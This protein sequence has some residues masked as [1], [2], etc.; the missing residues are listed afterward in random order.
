M[1][2]FVSARL[3][4]LIAAMALLTAILP[5]QASVQEPSYGAPR[6]APVDVFHPDVPQPA[7][8]G[9]VTLHLKDL[10]THLNF[11]LVTSTYVHRILYEAHEWLAPYGLE[12]QRPEPVLCR[13]W[14][15]E[16]MLVLREGVLGEWQGRST[17][18]AVRDRSQGS[19]G[20]RAEVDVLFG[21]VTEI[22][23]YYVLRPLSPEN[24]LGT[25]ALVPKDH[26]RSV[27]RGT[28]YTFYLREDVL[29]HPS[30]IFPERE[31]LSPEK[32]A[33]LEGE[34]LDAWDVHFSWSLYSNPEVDCGVKRFQFEKMPRCEVLDDLTVRVFY[35]AQYF[36]A[37]EAIGSTLTVL[38]RH[39]YDLSDPENPDYDPEAT[40]TQQARHVNE[41]PHN[42]LWVGLGPYQI[43]EYGQQHIEARRFPAYFNP[44][45]AGYVD[46]IR[47]RYIPD[48]G[49]A[50][51]ALLNGEID[52]LDRMSGETYL[53]SSTQ[54]EAFTDHYYKGHYYLGAYLYVCWNLHRPQFADRSVRVA[55]A[56]AIDANEF[57]QGYYKGLGRRVTGPFPKASPAYDA[58]VLP[59]EYDPERARVMLDE[60][61]WYDRDG[62]GVRERDG[63][64]LELE[65]LV[66]P[67]NVGATSVG[68][69]MQEDLA[70]VGI[71]LDLV[72][73]EFAV[74]KQRM[75]ARDFDCLALAWA[76]P[77]ESDPEQIWHSRWGAPD[78]VSSNNSGLQDE[79]IDQ[80]IDQGQLELDRDD[81]MSFW[82]KIHAR[83]YE[84]QP[85]LWLYNV[86]TKFALSRRIRGFQSFGSDPGY[87]IRRWH[88]TTGEPGTRS[89]LAPE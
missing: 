58:S 23:Q 29:W 88:F 64:E 12:S 54:Q 57:L 8:G 20:E 74:M 26:V 52:F 75:Q 25:A 38:P 44:S 48:D 35:E 9:R 70:A 72:P 89:T 33:A 3:A 32:L 79:Q 46:V 18:A 84:L 63:V 73:L 78:V 53:G 62:D 68:Q 6:T 22:E 4:A 55:M 15:R 61:G 34:T 86:P 10:P 19:Q 60:S 87:S 43:V 14:D 49:T 39:V 7:Y 85:Y 42:R 41:N 24:P 16:D 1:R 2:S 82:R 47:W 80:W 71:R 13:S 76:P 65:F 69:V 21:E 30:L 45:Q 59:L 40:A 28:V 11:A 27:E 67:G 17:R 56:H 36:K 51:Q 77:L 5:A 66:D 50:F 81:R 83:L 37:Q 31:D